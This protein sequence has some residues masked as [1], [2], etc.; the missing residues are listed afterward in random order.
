MINRVLD[1]CPINFHEEAR[2]RGGSPASSAGRSVRLRVQERVPSTDSR[3]DG[4][5]RQPYRN[6]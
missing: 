3:T 6:T 5:V 1:N 4:Y 2:K